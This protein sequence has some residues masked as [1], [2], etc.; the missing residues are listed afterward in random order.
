MVDMKLV[1]RI[2]VGKDGIFEKEVNYFCG[3][4]FVIDIVFLDVEL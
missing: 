4:F 2:L 3:N 1:G